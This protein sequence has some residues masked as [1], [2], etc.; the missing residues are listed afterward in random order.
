MCSRKPARPAYCSEIAV[1]SASRSGSG[2][3]AQRTSGS[4]YHAVTEF[5]VNVRCPA[6]SVICR[7]IDGLRSF[8]FFGF[9][10]RSS[11]VYFGGLVGLAGFCA[12]GRRA[13]GAGGRAGTSAD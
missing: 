9:G 4:Q 5:A 6:I 13:G 3:N 12:G 11:G 10:V 7:S 1:S 8:G 2:R